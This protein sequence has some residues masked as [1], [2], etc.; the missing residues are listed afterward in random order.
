MDTPQNKLKDINYL[1][2]P[3]E[4]ISRL[5][6]IA[7]FSKDTTY[8]L[9]F[10]KFPW[11]GIANSK[12]K[13]TNIIYKFCKKNKFDLPRFLQ[14]ITAHVTENYS[15]IDADTV[16]DLV[17]KRY[18]KLLI[19]NRTNTGSINNPVLFK[20]GFKN[21]LYKYIIALTRLQLLNVSNEWA[22]EKAFHLI[23]RKVSLVRK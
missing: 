21:S 7:D 5:D 3:G 4:I 20:S 18:N 13:D 22:V 2:F 6:F 14:L 23:S 9:R 19:E 8:P 11:H 12:K 16:R 15:S 1:K 10:N 17:D